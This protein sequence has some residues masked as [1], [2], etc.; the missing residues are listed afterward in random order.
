MDTNNKVKVIYCCDYNHLSMAKVSIHSL[1]KLH[2][3]ADIRVF[4]IGVDKEYL[5]N[6]K[7]THL[8]YKDIPVNQD[9]TCMYSDRFIKSSILRLVAMDYL[10]AKEGSGR[11][12]YVDAD[13]MFMKPIDH[14]WDVDMGSNWLG[15]VE[16]LFDEAGHSQGVYEKY[17]GCYEYR[18]AINP[19]YFNSGVLLFDCEKIPFSLYDFY[20][21]KDYVGLIFKD[22]DILNMASPDYYDMGIS[23]NAFYN[24]HFDHV[25]DAMSAINE[26]E[27][28]VSSHIVHFIGWVK[29][30]YKNAQVCRKSIAW[31][32]KEYAEIANEIRD[33]LP[34]D[35]VDNVSGLYEDS[36]RI[37]DAMKLRISK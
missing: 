18:L 6:F 35:F 22:Q 26:Y 31:P 8:N 33:E 10:K 1:L 29:P 5:K 34:S 25:Y 23:Y 2:P 30:H 36:G 4:T 16:E 9:D 28:L 12:L 27:R 3:D 21:K 15:A 37:L 19:K 24:F 17:D 32:L 7:V 20:M 11:F 13:T 14:L